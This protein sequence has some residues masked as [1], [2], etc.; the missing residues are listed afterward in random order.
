[1]IKPIMICLVV[2]FATNAY[3]DL[4]VYDNAGSQYFI[5]QALDYMSI[6]YTE[7]TS[8]DSGDLSDGDV[9]LI[10]W[11]YN[12]DMSGLDSSVWGAITGN[13]LLT[14]QDVD[15][16][17][18]NGYDMSGTPGSTLAGYA[19]TFLSQAIDFAGEQGG[20]GLV[21]LGD[22]TTGFA[23]L[24]GAWGISATGGL[25]GETITSFTAAGTASGVF[26]G[27]TPGNLSNWGQS[28]HASFD[29]WG[30]MFAL[31]ATG[32]PL[33]KS[34]TIGHIVPVPGAVLLGILGLSVA[35]VKLRRF[36]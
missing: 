10:P 7:M 29:S 18:Y 5:D 14:G 22:Y 24:P 27:L 28:Y 26:A 8:I 34:I 12:G 17:A 30:P 36:V 20:V 11:N 13:K 21:A 4:I 16:H 32:N 35:G 3:G 23:Y 19:Q 31:Y 33:V 15:V 2:L 9:L 1:M 6:S 25:L